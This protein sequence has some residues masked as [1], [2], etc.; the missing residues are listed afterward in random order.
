MSLDA[1][2]GVLAVITAATALALAAFSSPL[3]TL[4]AMTASLQLTV[5]QQAWVMSAMPLAAAAGLLTAGALGDT[6]GRRRTFVA[7]LWLTVMASALAALAGGGA[8]LIAARL[9]Q[10]LGIAGIMACGLG[11]LGQAYDGPARQRAAGIWAAGLGAGVALGPILSSA[12]LPLG[13]WRAVHGAVAVVA[14]GLALQGPRVLPESVPTGLRVD[15]LGSLLLMLGLGG[16]LAA[17]T[18]LRLGPSWPLAGL[19]VAALLLLA[20]FVVV[21]LRLANPILDVRL[22]RESAFAGATLAAFASGAGVLAIMSLVPTA[23][24]RG[25][26]LAPLA[27]ALVLLAWSGVT[28]VSALG[29]RRLPAGLSARQRTIGAIIGCTLAQVMLLEL[30]LAQVWWAALPGLLTAGIANGVLNAALGHSAVQSVPPERAAM[31]SA[32]NN[33]ARYMGSAIGIAA[34]SMLMARGGGALGT[35]WAAAVG[36]TVAFSLLGLAAMA[37]FGRDG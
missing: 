13:D 2:P 8:T 19:V 37:L 18:G 6:L 11:L 25:A 26:G 30:G 23:L 1:R 36:V 32:A 22:F 15:W 20:A 5:G 33:T 9:L 21:E 3:T 34:G 14:G 7:G 35:G 12:L 24:E 31:G 28:V 27:A 17:L 29:A 16:L 4:E 10:G